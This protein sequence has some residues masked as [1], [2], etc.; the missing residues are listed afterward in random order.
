MG[1]Y[2]N[3][4][5]RTEAISIENEYD[6]IADDRYLFLRRIFIVLVL[7]CLVLNVTSAEGG[8]NQSDGSDQV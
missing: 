1:R 6:P 7:L 8:F 4:L 2:L 3:I 5:T